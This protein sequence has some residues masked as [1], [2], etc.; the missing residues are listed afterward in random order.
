MYSSSR[1]LVGSVVG[2]CARILRRF[3]AALWHST[4]FDPYGFSRLSSK[5]ASGYVVPNDLI[6]KGMDEVA[7]SAVLSTLNLSFKS[8]DR[9]ALSFSKKTNPSNRTV[10]C[11][12]EFSMIKEAMLEKRLAAQQSD[13]WRRRRRGRRNVMKR[14]NTAMNA[15]SAANFSPCA[16]VV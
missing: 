7:G 12:A 6:M 15:G 14:N 4:E 1:R 9:Q 5:K 8:K 10:G 3:T 2:L 11:M 13:A 16:E